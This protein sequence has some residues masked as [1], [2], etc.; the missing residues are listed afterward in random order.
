MGNKG[1]TFTELMIV[2]AVAAISVTMAFPTFLAQ[3]N[4][5]RI[6][7]AGRDM[8]SHFQMARINA[9]RD[10]RDWAIFFDA[11]GDAY[12]LVHAGA[13]RH[14]DTG[15]DITVKTVSLSEYG[16]VSFGIGSGIGPRPGGVV[17]ENGVTTFSGNT[18]HFDPGGISNKSGTVYMKNGKGQTFAVGTITVTGRVKAWANWGQGW[19]E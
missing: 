9:M 1:F 16:D 18:F 3:R 2:V 4:K 17:P 14:L 6:K 8:V 10:G 15:D 12:R 11:A 7:R 19:E 13:D 5:A